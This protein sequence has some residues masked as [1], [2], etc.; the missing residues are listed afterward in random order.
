MPNFDF[1]NKLRKNVLSGNDYQFVPLQRVEG[2][3]SAGL[4]P[5]GTLANAQPPVI[6]GL[7][8]DDS[9]KMYETDIEP[10]V[11]SSFVKNLVN[12]IGNKILGTPVGAAS[13]I[14]QIGAN[15][16]NASLSKTPRQGG[17]LNDIA[18]GYRENY[19]QPF[20]IN[21]LGQNKGWGTRLGE[22]FGTLG[23]FVDSSLGRGIL[24]AG[25]SA[26]TGYGEPLEELAIATVGRQQAKTADKI[27]RKQLEEQ[28]IDTTDVTGNVD[29]DIFNSVGNMQ[30]RAINTVIKQQATQSMNKLRELQAQK[31][32]I[33]NS[34]LPEMQKAKLIQEIAKAEHAEEMQLAKIQAYQNSAALG[35]ANFNL[36]SEKFNFDKYNNPGRIM[37]AGSATNLSATLQGI[38][39]MNN[40]FSKINELPA[41]LTTPG[42]A[43][44]SAINPLDT[45]A[46]AFNQYVKTYKQVIGKGLEGGVLRKEDEYKY[47]QI[48]PKLGDTREVL[49]KKAEQLQ[50][51]LIDKYNTDLMALGMAGYNIGDFSP[52]SMSQNRGTQAKSSSTAI[53]NNN[54]QKGSSSVPKGPAS[55]EN[56]ALGIDM[57]AIDA[58]LKRRGAL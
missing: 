58:E 10:E 13:N 49:I 32:E 5:D 45:E 28:G 16:F 6:K 35:W 40:L 17:F 37:P 55:K 1:M 51:M 56:T 21:N 20:N 30:N 12:N 26:A 7:Q 19:Y 39:Q 44:M 57:D 11:K 41:R 22:G 33:E 9:G 3:N 25:L 50:D 27:Y 31:L 47:D 52:Y 15:E 42:V 54:T 53:K 23:R 48:I 2:A 36:N 18:N 4:M 14:E 29:K 43:N 24:A 34:T 8:L 38:E 46:Q